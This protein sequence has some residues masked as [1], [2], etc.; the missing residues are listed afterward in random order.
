MWC[1]HIVP[2]G[3]FVLFVELTFLNVFS[4]CFDKIFE[5]CK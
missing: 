4:I 3:W 5:A 2:Q 1:L